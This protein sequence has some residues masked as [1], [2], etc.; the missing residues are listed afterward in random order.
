MVEAR[1]SLAVVR[2]YD[3]LVEALRVRRDQLQVTRLPGAAG[4]YA[5]TAGATSAC[6]F[7]RRRFTRRGRT[8][9]SKFARP[10]PVK[11]LGPISLGALGLRLMVEVD[12]EQLVVPVSYF[13]EK[14]R[15]LQLSTFA[16]QSAQLGPREISA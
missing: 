14:F 10:P 8:R 16:T 7:G 15:I 13:R 5:V 4:G 3:E 2:T 9:A 6:G 1:S 12:P 11:N